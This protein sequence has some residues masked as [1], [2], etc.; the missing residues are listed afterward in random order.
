MEV[1]YCHVSFFF[2]L[3]LRLQHMEV[4]RPG[5]KLELQLPAYATATA[6]ATATPDL[7]HICNLHCSSQQ[8]RI[9]NL[10]SRSSWILIRFITTVGIPTVFFKFSAVY[11]VQK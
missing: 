1:S 5:V 11:L 7:R 2:F 3:G 8:Y 10:L 6:T 9:L 4:P